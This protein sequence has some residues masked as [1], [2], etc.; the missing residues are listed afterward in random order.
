MQERTL[1][2]KL[3]LSIIATGLLSF[4]G[5]VVETATNITFPTL[6]KE[7]NVTTSNVQWM[8]TGY[9][10]VA[11]IMMPLSAFFKNNFS[12]KKLFSTATIL[13]ILGL[14]MDTLAPIFP[15]LVLGRIIQ[16]I[17]AGIAL[18]L[19]FNI[20]LEQAPTE[21]IGLLMGI[22][23]LVTAIAPALGPTFG[24]LVVDS[25]GWRGIFALLIPVVIIALFLGILSI[26]QFSTPV[27]TKL[28]LSGLLMIAI[29]FIGLI[30]GFSNLSNISNYP[31]NFWIPFLVGIIFLVIF[32][33]H[34]LHSSHPLLNLE[35]FKN[36]KFTKHLT[37][38]FM[39]QLTALGL[40]FIL[41][42]YIQL[43][44]H[45]TAL[46]AGLIVLP[47]AAI[48][49]VF[50]PLGGT[51]LDNFGARRPIVIGIFLMVIASILFFVL[52]RS[53]NDLMILGIYI[54]YMV[55]TGMSFGN[56]MTNGIGQLDDNQNADGNGMFNMVQQ[57]AGAVGT[58]IV[59]AIIAI[60]QNGSSTA[61][62]A[63]RTATG[64]QH[65]FLVLLILLAIAWIIMQSATKKIS[66]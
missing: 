29:T 40:S 7:F 44:N 17:G 5:V 15:I 24:G 58:S 41:P 59:S 43:V 23:T 61:S 56:I 21:K 18:P 48:G 54:V 45:Q 19:M 39:M 25:L 30:I 36:T 33:R 31:N 64:S 66:D 20:I 63:V 6:M 2:Y 49:A 51:L 13:F 8:T 35:V 9:L 34:S 27:R 42:N 50:A 37:A 46:L 11:S 16:G 14:L 1:N 10:L 38:F 65:A 22:G 12:Y 26:K 60:S 55:G 52:G 53:L 62:Y 57:F 32:I 3:I 28:D 4:S 47:G